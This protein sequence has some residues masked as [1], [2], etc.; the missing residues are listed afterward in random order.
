MEHRA[1]GMLLVVAGA[2]I[3]LG[4]LLVMTGALSWFGH[5]PGDIRIEGERVHVYIPITSMVLTSIALSLALYVLS[6][7]GGPR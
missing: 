1:F 2:V 6:R 4:G 5:L 7:L 3:I